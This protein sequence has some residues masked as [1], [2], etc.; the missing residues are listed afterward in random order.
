MRAFFDEDTCWFQLVDAVITEQS[1]AFNTLM[2]LC[3][4]L[5]ADNALDLNCL[6]LKTISTPS[7]QFNFGFGEFVDDILYVLLFRLHF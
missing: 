2:W 5:I 3:W 1:V 6:D 7:V 4:H